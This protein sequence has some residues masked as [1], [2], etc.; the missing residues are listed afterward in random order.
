ML[1]T[2]HPLSLKSF[3]AM[4][5]GYAKNS[6]TYKCLLINFENDLMEMNAKMETKDASFFKMIFP[7]EN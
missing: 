3:D 6:A 2:K 5:I 1:F 4:P 7:Y